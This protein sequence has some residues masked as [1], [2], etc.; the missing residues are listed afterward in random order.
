MT[1]KLRA[2]NLNETY[3]CTKKELKSVFKNAD[4][5]VYFGTCMQS[6]EE[7][8]NNFFYRP[9]RGCKDRIVANL[10]V[11]KDRI[12]VNN[13]SL[14]SCLKFYILKRDGYTDELHSLFVDDVLPKLFDLYN[15]YKDRE[16]EIYCITVG[17]NNGKFIFYKSIMH[18]E[19]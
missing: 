9:N 15:K 13:I 11:G 5:D 4:L 19:N 8:K 6:R 7:E 18:K 14:G 10:I 16:Q 1:I 2:L 3:I 17:L 12:C